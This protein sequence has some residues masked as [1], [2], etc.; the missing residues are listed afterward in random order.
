MDKRERVLNAMN[1]RPVDHVPVGIWFHFSGEEAVGEGCIRA[2]LRYY[3]ET[4]LDFL[5][6]MSDGFPSFPF[7]VEIREAA[8]W[9]QLEPVGKDDPYIRDQV[10]RAKGIVDAIGAE[11]CVFYNVFAPFTV[12]REACGDDLVMKHLWE[13]PCAV[14]HGLDAA[15]QVQ[16]LLSELLIK[17]AG[18]DGIY[19]P[20]QGGELGRFTREEYHRWISSSDLYVLEHANRF[21]ENNILH[22]CGWAGAKNDLALWQNYPAKVVNWAVHVEGMS[23]EEGRAFF[24]NRACLGGFKTLWDDEKQDGI[25]YTGTQE[26]LQDYTRTLILNHGKIGL[27]LGGDCTVSDRIDREHIRWIVEAARSI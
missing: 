19:Y 12:I 26:E 22:C 27:L 9:Y 24:G 17:E 21:S 7:N 20:V 11:R 4:D 13:D 6:V 16:A 2:H 3:R 25:I 8:D 15:A 5:K 18:C 10:A 23:L 1:N 14:M